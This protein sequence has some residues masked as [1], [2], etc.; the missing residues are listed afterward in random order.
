[1]HK[2]NSPPTLPVFRVV[3]SHTEADGERLFGGSVSNI[4]SKMNM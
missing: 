4:V 1:M 2:K 3:L